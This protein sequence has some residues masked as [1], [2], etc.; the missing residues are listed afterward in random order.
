MPCQKQSFLVISGQTYVWIRFCN[1]DQFGSIW[2][3]LP[4][5]RKLYGQSREFFQSPSK[6]KEPGPR[7]SSSSSEQFCFQLNMH[8][9]VC[10]KNKNTF[11]KENL[12]LGTSWNT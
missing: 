7:H 10:I 2:Q 4:A 3:D 9:V 6:Y 1:L 11:L 8:I 12:K 5:L